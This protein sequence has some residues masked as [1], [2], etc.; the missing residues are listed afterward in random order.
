MFDSFL[1]GSGARHIK[2]TLTSPSFFFFSF[3]LFYQ[4]K[5]QQVERPHTLKACL[6]DLQRGD[7]N[8]LRPLDIFIYIRKPAF[9]KTAWSSVVNAALIGRC[10]ELLRKEEITRANN[11]LLD[12][13]KK[14]VIC[15]ESSNAHPGKH[16][17]RI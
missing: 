5:A 13:L 3:F 2:F 11:T 12:I 1:R 14:R 10:Q 4:L 9:R 17:N 16:M 8:S 6:A 15:L 7:L